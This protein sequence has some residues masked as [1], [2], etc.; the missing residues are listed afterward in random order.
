[1]SHT[2]AP[3]LGEATVQELREAV[4]GEIVT[5]AYDGYV[6]CAGSGTACTTGTE[7]PSS[8]VAAA[9]RT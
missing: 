3:V 2:I 4:H 1:M 6:R 5:P 7:R 8:S 9:L